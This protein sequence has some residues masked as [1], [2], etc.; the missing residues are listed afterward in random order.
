[1]PEPKIPFAETIRSFHDAGIRFVVIGGVALGAHGSNYATKD[2]DFAYAVESE[3]LE[4]LA[5]FLPTIHARVSGRPANDG[6]VISTMTLQ[7]AR[8]LNLYTDLGEVDVMREIGGIDSF[9]GLWERAIPMDLGGFV[10]RVASIDDLIAMKRSA[11]RPKDQAHIY[12]LL[13]LKKLLEASTEE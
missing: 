5:A 13:A 6:F 1:M 9:E 7:R 2:V 8:F 4:R 10:V 3:N 11:N 12:E